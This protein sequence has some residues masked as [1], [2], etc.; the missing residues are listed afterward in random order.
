MD[1]NHAIGGG[2]ELRSN[3]P[4]LV[5]Y[6]THPIS[7]DEEVGRV[8]RLECHREW[9]VSGCLSGG[10]RMWMDRRVRIGQTNVVRMR[11]G[12][13]YRGVVHEVIEC[14]ELDVLHDAN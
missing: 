5:P 11:H 14:N 6:V 3:L 4:L 7:Y 12:A 8:M 1:E 2:R 13:N 10:G 9:R